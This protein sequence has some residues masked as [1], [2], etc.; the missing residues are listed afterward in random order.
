M[1][2]VASHPSLLPCLRDRRGSDF[3]NFI[4]GRWEPAVSGDGFERSNPADSRESI[5]RFALSDDRDVEAAVDAASR[6]FPAWRDTPLPSRGKLLFQ[7]AQVMASR[8]EELSQA[9]TW[10]MGKPLA[11]ARQ[12]VQRAIAYLE[13][14]AGEGRRLGAEALPSEA[15]G[16]NY[17]MRR[18][19]GVVGLISPWNFPVNIPTIKSAP[20]LLAGNTVV[21]KP[22]ELSSLTA[23]L[24]AEIYAEAGVP[25][26]VFNLVLGDE[27]PGKALVEHPSVRAISFTGSTSVG[28]QINRRAAERFAKVQ[29]EMG[30][31][32]P[33]IVLADADLDR[34]AAEVAVG[35][36]SVTGQRC[37]AT[38]LALVER[39]VFEAFAQRLVVRAEALRSGPGLEASSSMGPLV[40]REAIQRV[41]RYLDAARADGARVLTGGD[42]L[43][44]GELR[45]GHFMEPTVI[46]GLAPDHAV[47]CEEVFGPVLALVPVESAQEGLAIANQLSYGLA[48]SLYTSNLKAAMHYVEQV[49][50]GVV[51]VNAPT[52]LSELQMPYGGLK[53]SGHGGREMGRYVLDFYTELQAVY[54][55]Y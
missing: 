6:A 21:L 24:L 48:S 30:G 53:E 28:R 11:E 17:V 45:Y 10:E 15:P 31:K 50:S 25:A 49:E 36:F 27:A 3:H 7:A 47:C 43:T 12:E 2:T 26:G 22:S 40:S 1:S 46:T 4:G 33:A 54:L 8:S 32:N 55:R 29:L 16:L 35:A 34:A 23:V 52:T 20:A 42:L 14:M 18:P 38:S 19:L 13:F 39:P 44:E 9:L 41:N 5:G 37:N 51:H